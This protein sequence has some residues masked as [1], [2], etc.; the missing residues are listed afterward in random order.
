[1]NF[2]LVVLAGGQC[3]PSVWGDGF[4]KYKALLND[5]QST[6]LE[7]ALRAFAP[8]SGI[9][10]RIVVGEGPDIGSIARAYEASMLGV[11][12]GILSNI[13]NV[14]MELENSPAE[15]LVI[16]TSDMPFL[17][18][19]A[20]Y[21][22]VMEFERMSLNCDF[23]YPI[24]PV[25]LCKKLAPGTKRTSINT[26]DG[27]FTGG[28]IFLA[29]RRRLRENLP[30]L[31]QILANRKKPLKLAGI[32]GFGSLLKIATGTGRISTLENMLNRKIAGKV[33][34]LVLDTA[35][36]AVDIDSPSEYAK[37]AGITAIS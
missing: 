18:A 14:L 37:I 20:T 15:H 29:N 36:I 5:G 31:E 11:G 19:N 7:I 2:D 34:A 4:P 28:N 21:S 33:C 12:N 23:V 6:F 26:K 24:V 9:K 25:D 16:S 3:D 17:S 30:V 27:S 32:L 10:R 13:R 22:L 35:E 8:L 1:M